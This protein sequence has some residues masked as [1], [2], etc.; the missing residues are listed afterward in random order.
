MQQ[1]GLNNHHRSDPGSANLCTAAAEMAANSVAELGSGDSN[2]AAKLSE[3][4]V[5]SKR[6]EGPRSF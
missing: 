6:A 4:P 5:H 1:N 2:K 3:L